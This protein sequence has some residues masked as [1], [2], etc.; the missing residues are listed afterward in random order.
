MQRTFHRL[1]RMKMG[2]MYV[3][4]KMMSRD[5]K[6][7]VRVEEC[8][9]DPN[10]AFS[11]APMSWLEVLRSPSKRLPR[12]FFTEEEVVVP[13][14][15]PV[16]PGLPRRGKIGG[17]RAV[18]PNTDK[19]EKPNAIKAGPLILHITGQPTPVVLDIHFVDEAAWGNLGVA[20]AKAPSSAAPSIELDLR[21]GL[22]AIEQCTLFSELRPGGLLTSE[23]L[24]TLKEYGLRCGLAQSPLVPRPWTRMKT[25]FIDELQRGPELTEFVGWNP[26]SGTN[27]RFS[28]HNV[29]FRQG[30]WKELTRR[31]DMHEGLHTFSS[32]QKSP[33][34]SVPGVRFLAPYP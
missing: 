13:R 17:V 29:Y 22:D 32:W 3:D 5:M 12:G 7:S 6:R 20:G 8:L 27:W 14:K 30:I 16:H 23:P 26:R 33:Q 28:Q 24:S 25:M 31:N 21:L 4:Y 9:V 18:L 2:H 19:K 1:F 15:P 11:V 34:Q 10:L